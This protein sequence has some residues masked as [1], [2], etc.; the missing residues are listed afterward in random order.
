MLE[1]GVEPN[2]VTYNVL[3]HALCRMR[4]IRL[5]Y[6][7]FH[8]MLERGLA[9]NKY[10]YTLLIDGNCKEGNWEDAI[11]LYFEM[12]QNDIPPDYCTQY[13]LF[14]GFDE[15]HMHH[16]IEYLENVVLGE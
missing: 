3:I 6:H 2:E 13:A 5:A 1:K 9:P 7:H 8:E 16:A 10:T 15:G 12:H 11:R 4:K 14:K